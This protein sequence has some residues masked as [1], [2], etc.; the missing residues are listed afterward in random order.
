MTIK[1]FLNLKN[2][3]S[4]SLRKKPLLK[5]AQIQARFEAGNQWIGM[6]KEETKSIIFSDKSKINLFIAMGMF[7]YGENQMRLFHMNI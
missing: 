1:R 3:G 5:P 6:S 2:H 4:F 7:L